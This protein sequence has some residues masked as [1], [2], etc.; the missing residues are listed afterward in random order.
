MIMS[1]AHFLGYTKTKNGPLTIVPEQ[2][3]IVRRIYGEFLD[4]YSLQE[5]AD[6]LM[7]DGIPSPSG[8][9]RWHPTTIKSILQNEKYMGDSH[10][11]KTYLPDFLSPRR[12]KNEG[13]ADSYYVEDS[14]AAIISKE[15]FELVQQEFVGRNE[16]RSSNRTGHGK[17]SGKYAFSG[18]IICGECGETYRRHQQYNPYKKY[19]IWVCKRHENTGKENCGAKPI[20]EDAIEK[21]FVRAL[22]GLIEN[23]EEILDELQKAVVT[24]V[25]D[26]CESEVAQIDKEIRNT[27]NKIVDLLMDKNGG[28]IT[29]K[30]Y[31]RQVQLLKFQI[32][33]LNLKKEI[34]L[35]EQGKVQ[36]AEY[37]ADAVTEL[38]KTGKI[39]DE[40]DKTIFKSLVR[41]IKVV[42]DK[43]IEI[44]FECGIKV[45]EKL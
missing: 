12:I 7:R 32:D 9:E 41:K 45:T 26:S 18:M 19:Y 6:G 30:Q 17:Y 40:F 14:H 22:N 5:I 25:S 20:R 24:Q 43:E 37:R 2:A 38:L 33:E 10:L 34:M 16:L 4:G 11:Q 39:L 15:M 28:L 35:N 23:R 13:Q 36:L 42:A 3:I 44:E 8:K 21:A 27:Q 1:T 29:D 31:E